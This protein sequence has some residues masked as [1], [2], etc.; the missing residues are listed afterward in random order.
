[1]SMVLASVLKDEPDLDLL[2]AD[3]PLSVVRLLRRC[4]QKEARDRLHDIAD[5]RLELRDAA[6]EPDPSQDVAGDAVTR[7]QTAN[8]LWGAAAV[9]VAAAGVF[10]VLEF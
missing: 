8:W 2:P 7:A 1:M 4:L 9:S 3:T 10:Y 5:A 6:S